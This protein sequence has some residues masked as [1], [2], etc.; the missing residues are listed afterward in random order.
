MTLD[1]SLMRLKDL[2]KMVERDVLT[3]LV[4]V[5]MVFY[6]ILYTY[7]AKHCDEPFWDGFLNPFRW[8]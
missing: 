6:L 4:I 8:W 5:W 1:V 7:A 3:D 2:V